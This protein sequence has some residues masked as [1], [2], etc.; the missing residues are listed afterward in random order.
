MELL[1]RSFPTAPLKPAGK[2][3]PLGLQELLV[4][5]EPLVLWLLLADPLMLMVVMYLQEPLVLW[6]LLADPLMLVMLVVV[7]VMWSP[8]ALASG[9][10]VGGSLHSTEGVAEVEVS[11]LL[12]VLRSVLLSVLGNPGIVLKCRDRRTCRFFLSD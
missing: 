6:L 12:S 4:L 10:G 7:V 2:A 11:V 8:P 3:A 5:Q 1:C 9:Q